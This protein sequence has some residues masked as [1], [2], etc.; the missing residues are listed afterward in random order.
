[1]KSLDERKASDPSALYDALLSTNTFLQQ[2]WKRNVQHDVDE[3]LR[4]LL[5]V[6]HL[7][8]FNTGEYKTCYNIFATFTYISRPILLNI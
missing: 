5:E 1:M 4:L 6:L 2:E 8:C 7:E 3:G